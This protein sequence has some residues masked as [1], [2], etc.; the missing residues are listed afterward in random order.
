MFKKILWLLVLSF[1]LSPACFAEDVYCG[2]YEGKPAY[3]E[4]ESITSTSIRSG[5]WIAT[6]DGI[7]PRYYHNFTANV[8]LDGVWY[9]VNFSKDHENTTNV[10]ILD[11]Y[12]K[13]TYKYIYTINFDFA[14]STVAEYYPIA[15]E[16]R[17]EAAQKRFEEADRKA[18]EEAKR[19]NAQ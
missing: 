14:Y 4:V 11:K 9:Q 2:D 1:L 17:N 13:K 8:L 16:R 6:E 7:F 15:K 19:N 3:L 18:I 5:D 10:M 12:K